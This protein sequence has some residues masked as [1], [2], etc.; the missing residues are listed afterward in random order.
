MLLFFDRSGLVHQGVNFR[1]LFPSFGGVLG[2]PSALGRKA[3]GEGREGG[4]ALVETEGEPGAG[5]PSKVGGGTGGVAGGAA[6]G[7][8]GDLRGREG[9]GERGGEEDG[10]EGGEELGGLEELGGGGEEE[11]GEEEGGEEG[12]GEGGEEDAENVAAA[13]V[14]EVFFDAGKGGACKLSRVDIT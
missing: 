3:E 13:V 5:G 9:R 7:G 11:E 1:F 12:G 6:G 14:E 10:G 8:R 4:L 2:E